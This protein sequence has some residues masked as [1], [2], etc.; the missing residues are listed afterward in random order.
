MRTELAASRLE[1]TPGVPAT[2]DVV[3]TNTADVIDGITAVVEGLDPSWVE[4]V[5]PVVSLFPQTTGTLSLRVTMPP[6]CPAGEYLVV[7]R[8]VS[9][10]DAGR[11]A[12]HD[13]WLSVQATAAASLALRPSLI[14][15]GKTAVLE[16][17]ITNR[18]N[19]AVEF[20]VT[21]RD[22]SHVLD[23][24]T[25]A[26]AGALVV[27]A[28]QLAAVTVRAR[29]P[30]PWFGQAASRTILVTALSDTLELEEVATFNQKPRIPRG[31][32]TIAILVGIIA[33]WATV[34]I[35]VVG[36]LGDQAA[37]TKSVATNFNSGGASNISLSAVAGTFEGVLL[38]S[39]TGDPLERVTVE[40]YRVKPD[41]TSELA[42]SAA[43]D[44][45]GSYALTSLLPGTY[46]L[47]F[48]ADGFD[49][50]WYPAAASESGAEEIKLAPS[51][52]A[53]AP[54]IDIALR[55]G[56]GALRGTV[57]GDDETP[58]LATITIRRQLETDDEPVPGVT[59]TPPPVPIV[60][61]TTGEF[62]VEGLTT[63]GTYV[64]KIESQGF[65]PQEFTETLAGG[66]TKVLNNVH[67]GAATG[68]MAGQV[69][70]SQGTPLGGVKVEI[71]SGDFK[72]ELT[73]P[74]AGN[75]GTYIAE[76]L[77]TPRTYVVTFTLDGFST[78]TVALE[79]GPGEA[80]Q[81][82][83][84]TLVG[85]SGSMQGTVRDVAGDPVGGVEVT[86]T[87]G[88]FEATTSTLTTGEG[89][90]GTF[91]V[92]GIPTPGTFT[93]TF[94]KDGFLMEARQVSITTAGPQE[95]VDAVLRPALASIEGQLSGAG[96]PLT[97]ATVT[98]ADGRTDPEDGQTERIVR[99]TGVATSPPG[100]WAFTEVK[101]GSYTL[102]FSHPDYETRVL[103]VIV[104]A[105]DVITTDA[106]L[107]ARSS[108]EGA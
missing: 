95:G 61:E 90:V 32:L 83:N 8:V 26:G 23:C 46:R 76:G 97:G 56:T 64:V 79:L 34:F 85:G 100:A 16:A 107:P 53:P 15:G 103:L 24:S 65:V 36:L 96:V 80:R 43:T 74:T 77:E 3:V 12:T 88:E 50:I 35:L 27:D 55:G 104:A 10:V 39:T 31:A 72:K 41:G 37:P 42:G 98:L 94:K 57:V 93:V 105:G 89:G 2:I 30:R 40:A 81:A 14:T 22:E 71:T 47:H 29:G 92:V 7:V 28:G 101:P 82:V 19:V 1:V 78:Q 58:Q 63:P 62:A 20:A 106:D 33:L 38:A 73:T 25:A 68:S 9:T 49:E 13:F 67:L 75:V 17:V 99:E 5:M 54:A 11:H 84:A 87:K 66:E 18:G 59:P 21:A 69:I 48:T 60:I 44:E 6:D 52:E 4:L 91:V 70:S 51:G 102:T 108:A 45:E 86:V